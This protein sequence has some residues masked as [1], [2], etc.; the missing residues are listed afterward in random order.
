MRVPDNLTPEAQAFLKNI[1]MDRVIAGIPGHV[2]LKDAKGV[3]IYANDRPSGLDS[4]SD[5]DTVGADF[6]GKTDED[7]PWAGQAE[8]LRRHDR[9]V[10]QSGKTIS[11][12]ESGRLKDGSLHE[13]VSVKAPLRDG[14]GKVIGVIG[15]SVRVDNAVDG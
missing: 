8:Q 9:N 10:M 2:Y 6:I 3:Y 12:K 11:F 15:V 14:S 1:N 13:F 7:F 5:G 4:L